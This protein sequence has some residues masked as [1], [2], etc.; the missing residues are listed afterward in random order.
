[1]STGIDGIFYHRSAD[2]FYHRQT[3]S[4]AF[5]SAGVS[6]HKCGSL[7]NLSG[8]LKLSSHISWCSNYIQYL[9]SQGDRIVWAD[10]AKSPFCTS[11]L[12]RKK[13]M[14]AG[15]ASALHPRYIAQASVKIWL[16]S[17]CQFKTYKEHLIHIWNIGDIKQNSYEW[18]YQST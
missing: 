15:H 5:S 9:F 12:I 13:R 11:S 10:I 17:W 16:C 8:K 4:S 6:S 7:Y 2:L 18:F 14:A 1:M 3:C